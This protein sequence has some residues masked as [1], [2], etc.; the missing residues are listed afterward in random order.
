MI[1][2][3]LCFLGLHKPF[4]VL[5]SRNNRYICRHCLRIYGNDPIL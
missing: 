4:A 5:R 3:F 2:R 1:R